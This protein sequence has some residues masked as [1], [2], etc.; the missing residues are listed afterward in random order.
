MR[1]RAWGHGAAGQRPGGRCWRRVRGRAGARVAVA[2]DAA[3]EQSLARQERRREAQQPEQRL[4]VAEQADLLLRGRQSLHRAAT[5]ARRAEEQD[6]V[7]QHTLRPGRGLIGPGLTLSRQL[8][9]LVQRLLHR[10]RRRLL[11][12]GPAHPLEGDRA[13][14]ARLVETAVQRCV[15]VGQQAEHLLRRDLGA[16]HEERVLA[17]AHEVEWAAHVEQ[18]GVAHVRGDLAWAERVSVS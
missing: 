12:V 8:D 15:E 3:H 13:R 11:P 4:R 16:A 7:T 14:V 1:P 2:A 6:G 17:A 5:K 10:W 9:R 18:E